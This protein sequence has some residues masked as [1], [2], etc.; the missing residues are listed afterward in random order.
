[1]VEPMDTSLHFPPNPT[2]HDIF[3]ARVFEEPFVPIGAE[4]TAA[5]NAALADALVSYRKHFDPDDFS[6]LT[7]FLDAQPDSPWRLALL[8]NLGIAYYRAGYYSKALEA[9]KQASEL[10]LPVADTV[11]KLIGD[12]AIGE[13]AYLLARLGRM[14]EL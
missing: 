14:T 8:T 2:P 4:P 9:W 3:C 6:S 13:L 12:R 1:M 11:Q 10:A 5:E 7:D